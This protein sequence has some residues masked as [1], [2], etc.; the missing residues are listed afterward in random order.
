MS[1]KSFYLTEGKRI[2]WL[3]TCI[4]FRRKSDENEKTWQT[5]MKTKKKISEKEFLKNVDVEDILDIGETWEDWKENNSDDVI[6][7]YKSG[8]YYFIQNKAFEYLW[9]T[10]VA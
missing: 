8:E 4:N 1:F 5:I 10:T 2:Q 3:G 6:N 7:F 9:R